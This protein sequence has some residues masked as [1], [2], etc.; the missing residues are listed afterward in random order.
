MKYTESVH[1]VKKK[2]RD[3]LKSDCLTVIAKSIDHIGIYTTVVSNT[4]YKITP[5]NVPFIILNKLNEEQ[6]LQRHDHIF[7]NKNHEI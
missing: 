3:S 7:A 1:M 2:I 5:F 4:W 6:L